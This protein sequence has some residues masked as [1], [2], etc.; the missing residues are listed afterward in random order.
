MSLTLIR[1]QGSAILKDCSPLTAWPYN[2]TVMVVHYT[3]PLPPA[4]DRRLSVAPMMDWTDRHCRYFLRRLTRRTLL[5]TEMI[6]VGAILRGDRERFLAFHPEERPLALQLGGADPGALAEAASIAAEYGYDEVN[7][8]VGCPSDRVQNA[9]FGACLMAEPSLVGRCVAAMQAAGPLPVTVKCRIGI[10]ERDRFEDLLSFVN[11]VAAAGC[12]SF[13]VHAR[14]AWLSGLSP[15]ENR[16]I[17]PLRYGDVYRLK[18]IRSGLEIVINGG[19]LALDEAER[20][21]ERVDG[22]MIGRAAYQNPQVLAEADA[23]LFGAAAPAVSRHD[24]VL[25][26]HDYAQE[27][28]AQGTALKSITR[29]MLGLFNGLPGARA[30]RRTLSETARSPGAGPALLLEALDEIERRDRLRSA[31]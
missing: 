26:M 14:K 30:W 21:L 29:H 15:K 22:A 20:H 24:V 28:V 5:Y 13:T 11:E 10:D 3:I 9:R 6:P 7:L 31:A 18:E 27:Q 4:A 17:P 25:A 1:L 12:R 23:R 8:N 19:I 2:A 16:E